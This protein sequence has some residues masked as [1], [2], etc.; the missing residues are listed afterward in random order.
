MDTLLQVVLPAVVVFTTLFG[1]LSRGDPKPGGVALF[2]RVGLTGLALG[3]G[4]WY[5]TFR[6]GLLAST[7]AFVRNAYSGLLIGGA[8][9]TVFA[10]FGSSLKNRER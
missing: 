10:A 7:P 4:L 1:L 9:L 3:G 5:L 6:T 8:V 2:W